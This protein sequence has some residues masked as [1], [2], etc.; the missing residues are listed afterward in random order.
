MDDPSDLNLYENTDKRSSSKAKTSNTVKFC[1]STRFK[2][3]E[4][5]SKYQNIVQSSEINVK[6]FFD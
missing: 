3:E 6:S 2:G 5:G 4:D 1:E